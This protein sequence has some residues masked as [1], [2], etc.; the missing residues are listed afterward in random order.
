MQC[1]GRTINLRDDPK[2]IEAYK[3]YHRN[4]WPEVEDQVGKMAITKMR[5]FLLDRRLFMYIE[6]TDDFDAQ[7]FIVR[8]MQNTKC[9]AWE[10]IMQQ[11]QEP[12]PQAKPGEW[13]LTMEPVYQFG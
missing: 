9:A 11:F 8:W 1:F 10:E 2:A 4:A 6:T 3:E 7:A 12:L 5:I 13:W